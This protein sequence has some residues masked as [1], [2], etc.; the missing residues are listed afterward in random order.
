[1]SS[2]LKFYIVFAA[3]ILTGMSAVYWLEVLVK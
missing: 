2:A 1:M 3:G